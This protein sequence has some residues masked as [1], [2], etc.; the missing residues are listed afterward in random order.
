MGGE[1]ETT[2]PSTFANDKGVTLGDIRIHEK[3]G[4][5]HFHNDSKK[6]KVAIPSG[7]WYQAWMRLC[8]QAGTFT[9]VD[10]ERNTSMAV[11]VRADPRTDAN[12]ILFEAQIKIEAVDLSDTFKSLHKFTTGKK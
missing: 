11:Q 5:V 8:D 1:R 4:E 2:V 7:V 10:A 6:L 3:A 12:K 9:Y